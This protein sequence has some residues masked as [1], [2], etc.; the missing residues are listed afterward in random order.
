MPWLTIVY[1]ISLI[2]VVRAASM[3]RVFSTYE[4]LGVSRD[5]FFWDLPHSYLFP[6]S[7]K[8]KANPATFPTTDCCVIV[9]GR[10]KKCQ[11]TELDTG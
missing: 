2:M 10:E 1:W 11:E 5:S 7:D 3:P 4:E 8:R 9:G 6:F